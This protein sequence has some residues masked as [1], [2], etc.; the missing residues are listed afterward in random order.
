MEWKYTLDIEPWSFRIS[1]AE[2][3]FMTGSCF[4]GHLADDLSRHFF[5]VFSHPMGIVYHPS[6]MLSQFRILAGN[7]S[8]KKEDLFFRE[9]LY[10]HFL[11][12]TS[13]SGVHPEEVLSRMNLRLQEAREHLRQASV[14]VLT[15]GTAKGYCLADSHIPVANCHK[16]PRSF[17][18]ESRLDVN[19]CTEVFREIVACIRQ[20]NPGVKIILTV[21]PV[22]YYREGVREQLLSKSVLLLAA[23]ELEQEGILYFP[24]YE[25]MTEELRDYRFYADDFCHPSPAAISYILSRFRDLA[26]HEDAKQLYAMAGEFLSLHHHR[27]MHPETESARMHAIRKEKT[28]SELL[29]A[30]PH[31]Q[32]LNYFLSSDRTS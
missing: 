24:A 4:A 29:D 25:L 32:G 9:G 31:I 20:V 21:S 11:F 10:G 12:H 6:A 16:F 13:F 8:V 5:R 15:P 27:I 3:W 26:L 1:A 7:A 2:S 22:K 23:K 17:F 14:L 19:A 30:F 18:Y 28:R